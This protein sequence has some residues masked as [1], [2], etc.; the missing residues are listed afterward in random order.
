MYATTACRQNIFRTLRP[1]YGSNIRL[2]DGKAILALDRHAAMGRVESVREKL[3]G[4]YV[5]IKYN[6]HTIPVIRNLL[7]RFAPGAINHLPTSRL[8]LEASASYITRPAIPDESFTDKVVSCWHF[9]REINLLLD[10]MTVGI[11][12][13][14]MLPL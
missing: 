9:A 13:L 6:Q 8:C 7:E 11:Q 2:L 5:E 12:E 3:E 10:M 4:L 14:N 1:R